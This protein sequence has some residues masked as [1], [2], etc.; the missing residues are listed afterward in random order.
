MPSHKN[1]HLLQAIL[2]TQSE[3]G[4]YYIS[5]ERIYSALTSGPALSQREIETIWLSPAARAKYTY[6]MRVCRSRDRS[7]WEENNWGDSQQLLAA[8]SDEDRYVLPFNGFKIVI[9]QEPDGY[10]I[11]LILEA[12]LS[13]SLNMSDSVSVIDEQGQVWITAV[14]AGEVLI[15]DDWPFGDDVS[16]YITRKVK[17]MLN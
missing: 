4:K 8:G 13:E 3:D 6:A 15:I 16:E 2:D 5:Y 17:I 10:V 11:S 9:E 12:E 7:T 14:P 1:A